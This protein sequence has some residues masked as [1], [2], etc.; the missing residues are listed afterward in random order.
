MPPGR[1]YICKQ[2]PGELFDTKMLAGN[3]D[4]NRQLIFR[5]LED[6]AWYDFLVFRFKR[7][8][9][10]NTTAAQKHKHF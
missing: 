10:L 7:K 8:I 5:D 6:F 3:Y 1:G 9:L 4:Q 2:Y